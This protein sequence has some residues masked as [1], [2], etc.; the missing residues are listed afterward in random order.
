MLNL[1]PLDIL[2]GAVSGAIGRIALRDDV[3]LTVEAAPAVTKAI[4]TEIASDPSIQHATNTEPWYASRVTWGAIIAA[5]APV[6]GLVLGHTVNAD[7]QATLGELA[8]AAGTLI[9]AGLALYGRWVAKAPIG[10]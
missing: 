8:T 7:D 10:A 3:P 1:N 4:L 9:G 6:L 5:L 2:L